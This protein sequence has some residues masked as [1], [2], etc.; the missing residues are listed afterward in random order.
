[1]GESQD[2][3]L[4]E[5]AES[6]GGRKN[7]RKSSGVGGRDEREEKEERKKNAIQKSL[8]GEYDKK[9]QN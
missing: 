6:E 8:I 5:H 3:K 4:W 9:K 7:G 2:T 1:M